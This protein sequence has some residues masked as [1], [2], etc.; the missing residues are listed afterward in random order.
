MQL[1]HVHRV[2]WIHVWK[3]CKVHFPQIS[4]IKWP[5]GVGFRSVNPTRFDTPTTERKITSK[6]SMGRGLEEI[7]MLSDRVTTKLICRKGKSSTMKLYL[8]HSLTYIYIYIY[9]YIMSLLIILIKNIYTSWK[10]WGQGSKVLCSPKLHLFKCT[11][12]KH[13]IVNYCYNLK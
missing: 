5:N 13:N 11:V 10:V 7:L 4:L 3:K 2:W 8:Y 9:I 1:D 6:Q 12:K